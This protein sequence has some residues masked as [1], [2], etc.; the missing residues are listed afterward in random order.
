MNSQM[1]VIPSCE[2]LHKFPIRAGADPAD[3]CI[4]VTEEGNWCEVQCADHRSSPEFFFEH[5]RY[6]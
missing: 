2:H 3:C 1:C 4:H 5:R 6:L